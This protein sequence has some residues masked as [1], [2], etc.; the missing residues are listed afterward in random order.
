M[1]LE[2]GWGGRWFNEIRF[3]SSFSSRSSLTIYIIYIINKYSLN[4]LR[5]HTLEVNSVLPESLSVS[6]WGSLEACLGHTRYVI[7]IHF[8]RVLLRWRAILER[9][10]LGSAWSEIIVIRRLF[11]A[12]C[13]LNW[14]LE[15]TIVPIY[16]CYTVTLVQIKMDL[17]LCNWI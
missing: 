1:D 7:R 12:D 17:W 6:S 13:R 5:V 15:G 14:H 9:G 3:M 8:N 4:T 2:R 10:Q 16:S 11:N